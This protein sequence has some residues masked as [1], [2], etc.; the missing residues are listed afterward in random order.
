MKL[1][2]SVVISAYNEEEKIDKC[3]SSV[4]WADEIVVMD[5]S[6]TDRTREVARKYTD[7]VYS[8]PNDP[9]K[10]DLQKN[11]GFEKATG[12]FILSLDADELVSDELKI[13]I[14]DLLE[15]VSLKDGYFI[16]R[17]N[18]IFGRIFEY[19]GW[20]PDHQL[21]LFRKGKGRFK[22]ENVHEGIKVDGETEYLKEHLVH[23]NY[24]N[25][26]Q[27]IHKNMIIYAKNQA[28][29]LIRENYALKPGDLIKTPSK[30]FLS[31]FFARK[32]YQDGI[33]GL[34]LSLLMAA[35]HLVML[36]YVWEEQ[37][38]KEASSKRTLEEAES[39]LKALNKELKFWFLSIKMDDIKNPL[40]KLSLKLKNK[41]STFFELSIKL[42]NLR[43][44]RKVL[45]KLK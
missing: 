17:K 33:H 12:D 3:L 1:K 4:K 14:T 15:K 39:E 29:A 30:E 23:H 7:K 9:F 36:A 21:R 5:N 45:D 26:S 28:N 42:N 6:S 44:F 11:T 41:S 43:G 10:I 32:G 16:P 13:E 27:F 37:G 24:E 18:I 25:I 20:Y 22:T 34:F 31:R 8:Q 35:S 40:G 2:L 19:A 38:F